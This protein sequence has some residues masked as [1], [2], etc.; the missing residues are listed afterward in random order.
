MIPLTLLVLADLA[1]YGYIS[2]QL[3][4]KDKK[5]FLIALCIITLGGIIL[6]LLRL[7]EAPYAL[8]M[9]NIGSAF[10]GSLGAIILG[11]VF[12]PITKRTCLAYGVLGFIA[13]L[14][15]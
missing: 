2:R 6:S 10:G 13:G 5:S 15:L 7:I 12:G 8:H 9:G 11:M 4:K 14:F 3:P 1:C